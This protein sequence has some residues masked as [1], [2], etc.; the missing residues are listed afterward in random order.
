[1]DMAITKFRR[2]LRVSSGEWVEK[3]KHLHG[4]ILKAQ[5]QNQEFYHK[6]HAR[7]E[8]SPLADST[9]IVEVAPGEKGKQVVGRRESKRA[10]A[11]EVETPPDFHGGR[12]E[13]LAREQT[14][15]VDVPVQL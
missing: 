6:R 15:G 2:D 9:E 13:G 7:K 10:K 8:R 4:Q 3:A 1:M 11:E 12:P 5:A 14:E